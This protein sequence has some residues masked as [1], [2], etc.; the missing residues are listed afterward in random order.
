MPMIYQGVIIHITLTCMKKLPDRMHFSP[1]SLS[2]RR[3]LHVEN[4][5]NADSWC[6]ELMSSFS[7][8]YLEHWGLKTQLCHFHTP[9]KSQ[10]WLSTSLVTMRTHTY[11]HECTHAQSGTMG[12]RAMV[13]ASQG[14]KYHD[15][16]SDVVNE[17]LWALGSTHMRHCGW[18]LH[19]S[20]LFVRPHIFFHYILSIRYDVDHI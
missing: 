5:I 9:S 1:S 11:T 12:N 16:G 20:S 14:V 6:L 13:H 2:R 8:L 4:S 18:Q 19:R 7:A 3:F 10:T 15:M 17:P